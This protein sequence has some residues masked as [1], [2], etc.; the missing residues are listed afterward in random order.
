MNRSGCRDRG[1]LNFAGRT[2]VNWSN[3]LFVAKNGVVCLKVDNQVVE[4]VL[5]WMLTDP[6]ALKYE[7]FHLQEVVKAHQ[8]RVA[9]YIEAANP[10]HPSKKSRSMLLPFPDFG[11]PLR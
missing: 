2:F 3:A 6:T 4:R 9:L 8:R 10:N 5:G 7:R 1:S 11:K